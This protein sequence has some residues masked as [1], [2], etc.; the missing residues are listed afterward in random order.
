MAHRIE[1]KGPFRYVLLGLLLVFFV[2]NWL[3][4]GLLA[5]VTGSGDRSW[6]LLRSGHVE[7]YH[8]NLTDHWLTAEKGTYGTGIFPVLGGEDVMVEFNVNQIEG[9]VGFRLIRYHW[10][11]WPEHVWSERARTDQAGRFRIPV[12]DTGFYALDLS[13][14]N[15]AGDVAFHWSVN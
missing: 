9:S 6:R 4:P 2:G 8:R 10:A 12:G 5:G 14:F 11:F 3:A 1:I 13:Y 15:F 7:R